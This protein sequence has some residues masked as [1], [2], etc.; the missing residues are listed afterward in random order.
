[1]R[2][3]V[4]SRRFLLAA[5]LPALLLAGAACGDG[6]DPVPTPT[7]TPDASQFGPAPKL[8]GNI[9]KVYPEHGSTV[10]QASTRSPDPSRPGG[11]CA[12][13]S[14]EGTPQYGQWFR[15]AVDGVEV[16]DRLTWVIPT[17]DQPQNGRVCYA[18]PEGLQPGKHEAALAVQDP[19]NPN[20][21]TKQVV[22]WAFMVS[23]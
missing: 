12:E 16:T 9:L 6:P 23:E 20:A 22:G 15:M 17:R 4:P 13:V 14:F 19:L 18:P 11:I 3:P 2:L 21:P 5:A 7:P 1:M 10:T 8:G